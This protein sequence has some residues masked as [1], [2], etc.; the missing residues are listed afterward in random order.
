MV[1]SLSHSQYMSL[2]GL[3]IV[4][5]CPELYRREGTLRVES[6]VS[7]HG[8]VTSRPVSLFLF[9]VS[10]LFSVSGSVESCLKSLPNDEELVPKDLQSIGYVWWN[11]FIRLEWR[12]GIEGGGVGGA[13]EMKE[14]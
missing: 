9:G 5:Y 4:V 2:L 12:K 10:L 3:H 13:G 6:G 14:V 11:I 1:N 8:V 7:T